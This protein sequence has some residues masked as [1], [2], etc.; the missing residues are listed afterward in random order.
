MV[1]N[2]ILRGKMEPAFPTTDGSS[3]GLTKREYFAAQALAGR[4]ANGINPFDA[5]HPA[6]A[7]VEAADFLLE[8]LE[9]EVS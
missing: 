6:Y 3:A 9:A 4:L 5:R 1:G 8:R 7:A 2:A